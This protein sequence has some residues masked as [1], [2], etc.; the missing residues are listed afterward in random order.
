MSDIYWDLHKWIG[1]PTHRSGI[2]SVVTDPHS[3][4]EGFISG[5]AL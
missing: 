2:V 4:N 1:I 5:L 3:V